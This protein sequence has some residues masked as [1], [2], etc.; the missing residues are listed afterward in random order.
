M[1]SLNFNKK[2]TLKFSGEFEKA[3]LKI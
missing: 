2:A 1:I 3:Q